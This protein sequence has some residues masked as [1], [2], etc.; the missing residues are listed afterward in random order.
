M[1]VRRSLAEEDGFTLTE[2][3]VT[4]LLMSVAMGALYSVFDMSLRVFSFGN[5]KT[6]AVENA[7]LGLER[8]E[9]EIRTA[10]PYNKLDGVSTN[11]NLLGGYSPSSAVTPNPSPSIT[12]FNDL[13]GNHAEDPSERVTYGLNGDSPPALLRNGKP[14]VEFV[15]PGGLSFTFCESVDSCDPAS[16]PSITEG[17]MKLVHIEL[18]V[19]V[20]R[21]ISGPATQTLAT[22]VKL[23]NRL[24]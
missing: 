6:E 5:D 20:D 1:K 18:R 12:F 17:Q 19:Q 8:M 7:R 16:P 3:M 11:D 13:N 21:G 4:I 24:R 14:L 15:R 22:D 10:Y 2:L 23:R 9:R